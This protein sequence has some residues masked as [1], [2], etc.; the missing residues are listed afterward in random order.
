MNSLLLVRLLILEGESISCSESEEEVE[1]GCITLNALD[2]DL[3]EGEVEDLNGEVEPRLDGG[4]RFLLPSGLEMYASF[5]LATN[6]NGGERARFL[7][8]LKMSSCSSFL[9]ATDWWLPYWTT[10]AVLL[11][12]NARE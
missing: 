12:L 7:A 5:L 2:F 1:E 11:D 8:L 6:F 10:L 4:G 3:G 9:F